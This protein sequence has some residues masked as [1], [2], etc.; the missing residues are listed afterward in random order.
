MTTLSFWLLF[1]IFRTKALSSGLM[2]TINDHAFTITL[3]RSPK[4]LKIIL[5]LIPSSDR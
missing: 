3:R 5:T 1:L 2:F 4:E